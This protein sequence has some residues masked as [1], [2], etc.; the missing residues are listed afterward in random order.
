MEAENHLSEIYDSL[1]YIGSG[2][3][4]SKLKHA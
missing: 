3:L 2:R 4:L 1:L